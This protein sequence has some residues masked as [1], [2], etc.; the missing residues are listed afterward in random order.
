[1]EG[2][3]QAVMTVTRMGPDLDRTCFVDFKT[4]DGSAAAGD[5]F[6]Y[7]EGTLCFKVELMIQTCSNRT[8][9]PVLPSKRSRLPLL[10][11]KFS[12]KMS[13]SSACCPTSGKYSTNLLH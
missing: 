9:R 6:E 11:M 4:L 12:K 7:A 1:M 8:F 5:D 2:C 13:T 3:G 10:T